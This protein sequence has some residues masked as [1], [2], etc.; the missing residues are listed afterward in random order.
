MNELLTM[1][2]DKQNN[3]YIYKFENGYEIYIKLKSD[4]LRI[5]YGDKIDINHKGILSLDKPENFV[6]LE[7]VIR[8]I[9]KGYKPEHIELEKTWH[10]GHKYK[11]RL[12]ILLRDIHDKSYAMIECKTWGD[13]YSRE[14][15]N[16]LE[17]GGQLFSYYI[18][19]R[20]TKALY[21]YSSKIDGDI[22]I[23]TEYVD[24]K[25]LKGSNLDEI[26][27]SWDESL[28]PNGI[29]DTESELYDNKYK[30]ITRKKLDPL[31][32]DSAKILYNG[33]KEIIRRH[34]ISDKSNAFNKIFNLFVCKIID[35]DITGAEEETGFQWKKDDNN[36]K[37]LERLKNL[38]KTGLDRYLEIHIDTRFENTLNEFLFIDVFNETTYKQNMSILKEIIE[39]LQTYQLKY[40]NKHQFLGDFFEGLLNTG[41]K[42]ESGQYFTPIPVARFIIRSIPIKEVI[43]K[44]I[45]DGEIDILPYVID[46][47]CGSGHFLTEIMDEIGDLI[48]LIDGDK[49]IGRAKSKFNSIKNDFIWAGEYVYGIEKDYRLAKTTKIATFLNGDGDAKIING[50]GLDDF[51]DSNTYIGRLK[52]PTQSKINP[53][54]DVVV[55]NPPYS[56]SNFKKYI[57]NGDKNFS[58][59]EKIT[60]NSTEIECL[61]LERTAQLLN[62]KGHAGLIF[63]L[64]LLNNTRAVYKHTRKKLMLDFNIVGL[65]EFGNATFSATNTNTICIFLEKRD[66]G[67]V[68]NL[69]DNLYKYFVEGIKYEDL[70]SKVDI[71][72][73]ESEES[74]EVL[75]EVFSDESYFNTD[76]S[77]KDILEVNDIIIKLVVYLLNMNKKTVISFSGIT[78]KEQ[79][80]YLGYRIAAGNK[81][82]G[83]YYYKDDEGNIENLMYTEDD[84]DDL[85]KVSTYIRNNYMGKIVAIPEEQKSYMRNI[86][87]LDLINA[88]H[89]LSNPSQY[90]MQNNDDMV[91]SYSKYGD[92]LD[93]FEYEEKTLG[94]L[95]DEKRINICTGL[96]YD[97]ESEVPYETNN[98]IL[99]ASNIDINDGS[100]IYPKLRYLKDSCEITSTI[101]PKKHDIVISTSSGSLKHLGKVAY[102][103]SNLEDEY[104]GGF[105][106]IIRPIE[107]AISKTIFYNLQSKRFR[108]FIVQLKD[109]NINNLTPSQLKTFNIRIP[110][111]VEDFNVLCRTKE[112]N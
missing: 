23:K 39:L 67:E 78:V 4:K 1:G 26:F 50:D 40:S 60:F 5:D 22:K 70:E 68:N 11:G 91:Y 100:L 108:S 63:P 66:S 92:F 51:N 58:L 13:E 37:V 74:F 17:D 82:E 111:R 16:M 43:D 34:T 29:F 7:C 65:C 54:F 14:R 57:V 75:K 69:L 49:L 90:F 42:Q 110:K 19:E 112:S 83:I 9:E 2:F 106:S 64:S 12:D 72:L 86:D 32:E 102:V 103:N 41:I 61:F 95:I 44:K 52:I 94:E 93:E 97:K 10:L 107:I 79:Q 6:V 59:Y 35:E 76:D 98:K 101:I 77:L 25:N 28:V 81:N 21:L 62:D 45:K 33:F 71:Y 53:K 73:E 88:D 80:Y 8:L 96:I 109:Q 48:K 85:R 20:D 84:Y 55:S 24:T 30:N 36:E 38:Y 56:V 105:L 15:N 87:T 3:E 104:I 46:Y 27:I 99:T 18:Q 47:A 89:T 31:D